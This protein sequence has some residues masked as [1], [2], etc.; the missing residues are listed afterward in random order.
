MRGAAI[1]YCA[2]GR[3][4]RGEHGVGP[5]DDPL[6]AGGRC[7]GGHY[8][9]VPAL[10]DCTPDLLRWVL[11]VCRWGEE[12]MVG[13]GEAGRV[14]GVSLV[15]VVACSHCSGPLGSASDP[16]PLGLV[17]GVWFLGV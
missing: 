13:V 6:W 2:G 10:E 17:V 1:P 9:V 15:A 3:G 8:V 4:H 11:A 14:E 5:L 16:S 7:C 12:V